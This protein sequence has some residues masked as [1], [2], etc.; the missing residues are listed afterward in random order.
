MNNFIDLKNK[1]N[2][3][4][5]VIKESDELYHLIANKRNL[6]DSAFWILY[7]IRLSDC[8]ITQSM[9]CK[10]IFFP[11]QTINSSLKSLEEEGILSLASSSDNKK[12]KLIILTPKGL[13]LA[14]EIIDDVIAAELFAL[15]TIDENELEVFL[16]T[17]KKYINLLKQRTVSQDENSII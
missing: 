15:E 5:S 11:K 3:L 14:K 17:F 2:E 6:S 12:N 8:P 1:L 9:L 16:G 13:A 10:H 4:N 7:E